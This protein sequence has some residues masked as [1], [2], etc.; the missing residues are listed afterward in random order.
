MFPLRKQP[1][2]IPTQLQAKNIPICKRRQ[3]VLGEKGGRYLSRKAGACSDWGIEEGKNRSAYK[4]AGVGGPHSPPGVY[5][6]Q[7][8]GGVRCLVESR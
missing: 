3:V 7:S 5:P 2:R 8:R 6:I 1:V 4:K